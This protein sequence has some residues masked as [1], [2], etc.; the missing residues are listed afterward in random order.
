MYFKWTA[1]AQ[2]ALAQIFAKLRSK[3]LPKYQFFYYH[4]LL[5]K[6]T[7]NFVLWQQKYSIFACLQDKFES[8]RYEQIQDRIL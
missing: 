6:R 8:Y 3:I 2:R 1:T 4:K 5:Q 7:L